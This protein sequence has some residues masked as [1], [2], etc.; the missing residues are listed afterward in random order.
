M[1]KFG[2][3]VA[4]VLGLLQFEGGLGEVGGAAE[5]APVVFVGAEGEDSFALRSEAKIG[6]DDGED[7]FFGQHGEQA[8]RDD[9]DAG[10][11]EGFEKRRVASGEWRV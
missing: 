7:A 2:P 6:V 9:V 3:R 8:R 10:E 5:V 4:R 11:G 1:A